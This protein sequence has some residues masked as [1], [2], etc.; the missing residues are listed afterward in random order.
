MTQVY[1]H[2][3][4]A[5]RGDLTMSRL[6]GILGTFHFTAIAFTVASAGFVYY[7]LNYTNSLNALLYVVFLSPVLL[8]FGWWYLKVRKNEGNADFANTMRLN[9]ISSLSLNA[10]FLFLW[11][12]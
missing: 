5:S 8:F 3:E 9:F 12:K 6:M 11:I 4:D 7:F 10:F 2:D 1:Q